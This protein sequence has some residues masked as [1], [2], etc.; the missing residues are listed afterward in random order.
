MVEAVLAGFEGAASPETNEIE[1]VATADDAAFLH[2]GGDGRG[3]GAGGN[4]D[5]GLGRWA[6]G[7]VD[8]VGRYGR[9]EEEKEQ[10][11]PEKLQGCASGGVICRA[12]AGSGGRRYTW[13]RLFYGATVT[14]KT[15][16][17]D[18]S[19]PER[20]DLERGACPSDSGV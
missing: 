11:G 2:L 7:G 14:L 10:E 17:G 6:V 13:F 20:P 15:V 5:E 9:H 18:S 3:A 16:M 12:G 4:V 8:D 1:A 19:Q